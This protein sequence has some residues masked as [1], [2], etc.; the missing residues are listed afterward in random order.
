M[1]H[2]DTLPLLDI[3][4]NA[5]N[6]ERVK[7]FSVSDISRGIKSTLEAQYGSIKVKGEA[8]SIKVHT[9]G[10]VYFSL[11]DDQSLLDAVCWKG[12]YSKVKIKPEDGMEIIC[13]GKITT[14]PGRSKYQLMVDN[15]EIAGQGE[16]LKQ[17][18][19]R[20]RKLAQEGLFALE[21]K[22]PLPFMPR[23]IGVVTSPTGAVI[24]D[25]LHRIEDRFPTHVIIWPVLVQ[26]ETAAEQIAGAVRGFNSMG[27]NCPDLLI[28]AR[29]GGSLEDLWCFNEEIVVRAV[30]DSVIPIISAVGHE[31]DTTLIDYAADVRAPTPTAA[32]EMA[33][34]VRMDLLHMLS[35]R[36]NRMSSG[37][38]R[39]LDN[40]KIASNNLMIRLGTP[41]DFVDESIQKLDDWSERMGNAVRYMLHYR[42]GL[43][44]QLGSRIR[45]PRD[46]ITQAEQ[47]LNQLSTRWDRGLK[48]V[49]KDLDNNLTTAGKLLDGY[50]YNATLERGFAM[51]KSPQGHVISSKQETKP[52]MPITLVFKDGEV[53][54]RVD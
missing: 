20:K 49:I 40:A 48:A 6:T 5:Q 17:L 52:Q 45:H 14:Y 8:S 32:A 51:V 2:S 46:I 19:E 24:K 27:S 39:Y 15:I 28:V 9:S 35:D 7:V 18:E 3:M 53:E 11:K 41:I 47:N 30:A 31:T 22:K 50:S 12:N 1:Q 54:A 16:L 21:R 25:I 10:H 42:V 26:G 36:Y 37:T 43:S 34:P 13:T 23:K 33:V 29:G 4:G 38:F 44:S